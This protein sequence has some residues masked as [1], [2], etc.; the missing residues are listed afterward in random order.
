M[1][2][3]N[4]PLLEVK[5]L[6][7]FF[8]VSQGFLGRKT[9]TVKAVNDVSF[10][11]KRG[12]TLGIVGESGCGKTT[13]GRTLM[14]LIEPSGG[15]II[16]DGEDYLA[17]KDE[18]LRK[19]RCKM[20]IIFQ[21]PFAS[22][23]PRMTLG[24][25]VGEPLDIQRV[26]PHRRDRNARVLELLETVG[27]DPDYVRRYAHELSGGQ[28]QR[29]GIARALALNPLMLIC[30]EPVSALDV[31]IQAQI[32][33]LMEE[34]QQKTGVTYIFISHDLSVVKHVSDNVAVMYLGKIVEIAPKERL[35]D[36]SRHPYTKALL[37]AIPVPDTTVKRKKELMYG[38]I[39]SPMNLPSGCCFHTR[40][41]FAKE[42]CTQKEP[43]LKDRNDGHFCACHLV[44]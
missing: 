38:D 36:D 30:D 9:A 25:L 8:P 15:Q 3:S 34:I 43:T 19:K 1:S 18:D 13:L 4:A 11:V 6:T 40:C 28:R 41:P 31:S 44:D 32:L 29:I 2:E 23:D 37:A 12:E 27:L 16:F 14:R 5:N 22:L 42:I 33:N 24:D 10:T 26:F 35:Y 20:Q 7:K 17:L 39:P 21:D